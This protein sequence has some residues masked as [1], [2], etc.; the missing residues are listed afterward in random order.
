MNNPNPW[1]V[2]DL[3]IIS[4]IMMGVLI[5]AWGFLYILSL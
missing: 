4:I 3:V 1:S 5:S 2:A